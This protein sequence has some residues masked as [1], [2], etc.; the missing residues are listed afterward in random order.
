M[1]DP[2]PTPTPPDPNAPTLEGLLAK[3]QLLSDKR[4]AKNAAHASTL[5]AAQAV[6]IAQATQAQ[7]ASTETAAASDEDAVFDELEADLHAFHDATP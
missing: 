1:S 7:A 4:D 6:I 2:G 5:A 3:F